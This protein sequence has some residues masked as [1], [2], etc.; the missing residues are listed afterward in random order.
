M[1]G[2]IIDPP[3]LILKI[4]TTF[5]DVQII[6]KW[7]FD[8][9][10]DFRFSKISVECSVHICSCPWLV[11]Y[12]TIWICIMQGPG[13]HFGRHRVVISKKYWVY[14]IKMP[15]NPNLPNSQIHFYKKTPQQDFVSHVLNRYRPRFF[16]QVG[17]QT[18][19]ASIGNNNFSTKSCHCQTYQNYEQN[20]QKL[21][22]FL[23]NKV[24]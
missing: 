8:I 24:L 13:A 9:S 1:A 5:K 6:L 4:Y 14:G 15:N 11:E 3:L 16:D 22:T 18:T 17:H 20:Q 12:R 7:F 19:Y 2:I 10:T 21:G 23:E